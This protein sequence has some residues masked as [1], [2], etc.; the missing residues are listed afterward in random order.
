MTIATIL[1][2]KGGDVASIGSGTTVRD[3]VVMLA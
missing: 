3:A 1:A 2:T